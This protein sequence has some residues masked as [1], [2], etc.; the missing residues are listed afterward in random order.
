MAEQYYD[1]A[2]LN[3]LIAVDDFVGFETVSQDSY[4]D[5]A[6][7]KT[8]LKKKA[9]KPLMMC[10]LQTAIVGYGN[11]TYGE[12]KMNDE[13]VDVKSLYKEFGVKDD[14]KQ[15]ARLDPGDLTP[16]RLQRF[17]RQHIKKYLE[18]ND[19]VYPYL[20]KKYSVRDDRFRT[21]TFPGAESLVTNKEE[22]KF[23]LETYGELDLRL[24]TNI[25]ERIN[26]VLIARKVLKIEE[27]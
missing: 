6:V 8:I 4:S 1:A 10:A 20:W 27:M 22:A 12:F 19:E 3:E 11:K 18:S 9:L 14:L 24:G 16:R 2:K 25:K 21:V 5:E 17:Y 13:S 23:L 26:R 15:S 7:Y